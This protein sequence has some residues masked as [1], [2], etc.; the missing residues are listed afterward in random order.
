MGQ[1]YRAVSGTSLNRL[2][3]IDVSYA[4]DVNHLGVAFGALRALDDVSLNVNYGEVVALLGPNGAGKTT[5]VETLLGFPR[6]R[7]RDAFAF[8]DST[9]CATTAKSSCAPAPSCSAAGCGPR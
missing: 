5:L 6:A 7:R 3:S 9:P 1:S 8:T 4:V 2:V